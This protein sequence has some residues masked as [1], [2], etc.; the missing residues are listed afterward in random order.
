MTTIRYKFNDPES[1]LFQE[2]P[3]QLFKEKANNVNREEEVGLVNPIFS[4]SVVVRDN[5]EISL[6]SDDMAQIRL[7]QTKVKNV[8]QEVHT[9][10]NR[11]V[12]KTDE[13]II[14]KHKMNPQLIELSDTR[15]LFGDEGEIIGNLMMGGTVMVKAW[16]PNL[17]KYV[18]IRRKIRTP[19][20][21]YMLNDPV[22]PEQLDLTSAV[23]Y[24]INLDE[25]MALKLEEREKQKVTAEEQAAV[26]GSNYDQGEYNNYT[27]DVDWSNM[28]MT[29]AGGYYTDEMAG[30]VVAPNPNGLDYI[31]PV[32]E[33]QDAPSSDYGYRVLNGKK[34]W[35]N[36]VDLRRNL[37]KGEKTQI[38]AAA[39]G[40]V[41]TS[42][43]TEA[44]SGSGFGGYGICVLIEHADGKKTL[45]AHL[46]KNFVSEGQQVQ[47]G[48][49]IGYMGSTGQSSGIH[50]HFT[51]FDDNTPMSK[52]LNPHLYI[53]PQN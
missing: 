6:S 49:L 42:Y 22:I 32:P 9:I 25:A 10:T 29:G 37:E 21:S 47:Q 41:K 23:A 1:K 4:N 39:A 12:T 40:T 43:K 35:H 38:V 24:S 28:G 20:F 53:K 44:P 17:N 30:K 46:S 11:I 52:G 33:R 31:W 16:E 36:G 8:A 18:L 19:L 45:Y 5:G 15:I 14:N 51:I 34:Q 26:G 48:E 13:I 7:N 3:I 27:E 50:L 2:D